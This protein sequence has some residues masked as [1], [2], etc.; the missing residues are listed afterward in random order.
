MLQHQ[1][2]ALPQVCVVQRR[3]L[4]VSLRG[5][6][7]RALLAERKQVCLALVAVNGQHH[8]THD[9]AHILLSDQP[10]QSPVGVRRSHIARGAPRRLGLLPLRPALAP[11][12]KVEPLDGVNC[13]VARGAQGFE[14]VQIS[15]CQHELGRR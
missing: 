7:L 14:D 3:Q 10:A 1:V 2:R 8:G 6:Q 12:R 15:R 5:Q 13:Q 4:A 9:A 11:Y